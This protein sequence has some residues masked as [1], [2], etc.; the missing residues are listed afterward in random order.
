MAKSTPQQELQRLTE[1]LTALYG[2]RLMSLLVYG[3][4]AD[5]KHPGKFSDINL[6]CVLDEVTAETLD[7]GCEAFRWWERQP[8]HRSIA[9]L[10]RQEVLDAADV[11]PIEYLDIR[12]HRR[13]L[14]GQD[15]FVEMPHFAREHRLQVEHDLRIQ[16]IRLRARYVAA[17][18]DR[19][20]LERLMLQSVGNFLTL[21]RHAVA[22]LGGP[23]LLDKHEVAQAAALRFGIAAGLWERLLAARHG[24]AQLPSGIGELKQMFAEYLKAIQQVERQLEEA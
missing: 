17:G 15:L 9:V 23:W 11:F 4:M 2:T 7:Q 3:S 14:A 8:G 13:V 16:L 6:L 18:K 19:K 12:S 10:T 1:W 22:T 5:G 21:F 20:A 24:D